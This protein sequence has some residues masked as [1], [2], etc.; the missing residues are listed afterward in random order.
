MATPY[1]N[2]H[3]HS[4]SGWTPKRFNKPHDVL[5]LQHR[6]LGIHTLR[7][8]GL[9][10]D[11]IGYAS[12]EVELESRL[13]FVARPTATPAITAISVANRIPMLTG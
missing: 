12:R 9:E 2:D 7:D 3:R 13:G 10:I 6:V 4:D 5:G 8:C 11:S 1:W